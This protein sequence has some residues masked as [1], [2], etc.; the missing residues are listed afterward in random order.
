MIE[1]KKIFCT[2]LL[3]F[4]LINGLLAQSGGT[5]FDQK[6]KRLSAKVERLAAR[7]EATA[8][9]TAEN[10]EARST[11]IEARAERLGE[12]LEE[13][14]NDDWSVRLDGLGKSVGVIFCPEVSYLGIETHMVSIEKAKKLGFENR[15]GSYVSKVMAK[16]S[17]EKGGLK[18]FDYIYGVDEQRTSDNQSL[19]DILE[20]YELGD[21]ITLHFVRKGEKMS[22]KVKLATYEYDFDE[23]EA[24]QAFLGVSPTDE[25]DEDELN[26]VAVE[27][28]EKSTAEEMGLKVGDVI[29]SINGFPVLDWE[30]VT[31]AIQNTKPGEAIEVKFK[32]DEKEISG[33]GTIKSYDE[34]YPD[35][36]RGDWNID[37]DWD[38][39]GNVTIAGADNWD[40]EQ[41]PEQDENRAF[42]GIYTEMISKEKA[43]KLGLDNPYGAY[44]TGILPN[45]GAEKAGIMPFDYIYG[46]DE[47]R[48]GEEQHL[49]IVLKKFKPGQAA[50]V[51]FIRKGKASK[52]SL[53]L[54]K[55]FTAEKKAQNSCEDTFLG[56]IQVNEENNNEG[57]AILPV[58]GSTAAELSLQEGDVI[59]HIN[60]YRMVDWLDVTTAI[61]MLKPGETISVEFLRDGKSM[62]ASKP[63]MSYAQTKKCADC[64]CGGRASVVIAAPSI[65][66]SGRGW[67]NEPTIKPTTP[68]VDVKNIKPT[69][70]AITNEETDALQSKGVQLSNNSTLAVENL[71]LTPNA[72]TGLFDLYF[73]LPLSGNT[74][75]RIYNLTGRVL[76]EYDL[77]SFSGKFSDSVDISQNGAGN[78]YLEI[79]QS[80]K[81]FT[82]KISLSKD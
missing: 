34:V 48:A 17:G 20:D 37:V 32:R 67:V 27:V 26:G 73:N 66:G 29:T 38:D 55:P 77:G 21:E 71:R 40:Q 46:F 64:D 12:T 15:Y 58:K 57:V 35:G 16:S 81:V 56:I 5:S 82:K 52:A 47:Y 51:H 14:W 1:M 19:S 76:Y 61:E 39:I 60:G 72:E 70:S 10:W 49:G 18:A 13:K 25:Q 30:D 9:T 79:S 7:V 65:S 69:I 80:G 41:E 42:I 54:T 2:S 43:K 33:K 62:K 23:D 8:E 24:Q 11:R 78:Y 53:T 22:A 6:L 45:S 36:E 75:V 68:R 50:T 28:V 3:A 59:T 31:T 63:I 4:L 44:V 74:L